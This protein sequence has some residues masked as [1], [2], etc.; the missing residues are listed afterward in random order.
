MDVEQFWLAY[1]ELQMN[2][3]LE[4][5]VLVNQRAMAETV[6]RS[7]ITSDARYLSALERVVASPYPDI[8]KGAEKVDSTLVQVYF[9]TEHVETYWSVCKI[10]RTSKGVIALEASIIASALAGYT[11]RQD[12]EENWTN[13]VYALADREIDLQIFLDSLKSNFG[14]TM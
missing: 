12:F 5:E 10:V 7:G 2:T 4:V 3:D 6:I 13:F 14:K 11:N 9:N 8:W 1:D